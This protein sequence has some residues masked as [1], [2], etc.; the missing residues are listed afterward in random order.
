MNPAGEPAK[1]LLRT[2]KLRQPFERLHQTGSGGQKLASLGQAVAGE[3]IVRPATRL[4]HQDETGRGV[5]RI[6]VALPIAVKS[7]GGSV[8]KTERS[9]AK[10]EIFAPIG[11]QRLDRARMI[12]DRPPIAEADADA[13]AAEIALAADLDRLPV[14]ESA[15]TA[16]APNKARPRPGDR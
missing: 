15:A 13:G 16:F 6:D 14:Q 10:P 5:P 11:E 4:A 12:L 3:E 1:A 2:I 7:T 8:G 9:G